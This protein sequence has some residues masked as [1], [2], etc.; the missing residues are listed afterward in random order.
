MAAREGGLQAKSQLTNDELR[1]I[2]DELLSRS[3]PT[4]AQAIATRS[5]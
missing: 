5:K 1:D 4:S 3:D 2:A